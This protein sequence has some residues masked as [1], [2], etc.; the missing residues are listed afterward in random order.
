MTRK[1]PLRLTLCLAIF[2]TALLAAPAQRASAGAGVTYTV[3]VGGAFLR[4]QPDLVAANTQPVFAGQKYAVLARTADSDWVQLDMPKA[5]DGAW[6]L[7]TFGAL[8]ADLSDTPIYDYTP[9]VS[10]AA[11]LTGL[12][13]WIPT[14]TPYMRKTYQMS[15][16]LGRD[17]D[18]FTVIGD[19]NSE[20]TAYLGRL[21]AGTFQLPAGQA[22]LQSTIERFSA[23]FPRVSLATHG[24]FGTTAMFDATW[25]D[26]NQCGGDEGPLACELR[27]SRASIAFI[28][29]GTGDQYDWQNFETN[30]RAVIDYTLNAGVLPVLVTKA[31]DLE[32]HSKAPSGA[33]NAIIRRLGKAY[34][35]PVMDFWAATRSLP[36]YGL[37]NEGNDNFHMTPAGSDTRILATLQTLYALTHR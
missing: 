1:S 25:S 21:A 31:D 32:T 18:V 20:S 12:P 28:A 10:R 9:T 35:V 15:A 29:L 37:R 8:S 6:I 23:S 13:S 4:E 17:P 22:Y 7:T 11:P 36:G 2:L 26:P 19:C 14:V 34:G 33:I 16:W 3:T 27:V 24:S 5:G 30:Y